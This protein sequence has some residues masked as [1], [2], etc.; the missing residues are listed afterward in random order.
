MTI[1]LNRTHKLSLI[2][3][4]KHSPS[5]TRAS[6][7]LPALLLGFLL[8]L[9]ALN[10]SPE[11][12]ARHLRAGGGFRPPG[13]TTSHGEKDR[14]PGGTRSAA[15]LDSN[16]HVSKQKHPRTPSPLCP[17][18]QPAPVPP[19]PSASPIL[20]SLRQPAN[21]GPEQKVPPIGANPHKQRRACESNEE[22][23]MCRV[24]WRGGRSRA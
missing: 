18:P 11:T 14:C 23:E 24:G 13:S 16:P 17:D 19:P 6:A 3:K 22:T 1:K 10:V 7:A 8:A 9:K 5:P 2:Q 21:Q 4:H 12:G 15:F 20:A